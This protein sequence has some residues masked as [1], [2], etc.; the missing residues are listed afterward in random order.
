MIAPLILLALLLAL[1]RWRAYAIFFLPALVY[2]AVLSL[3]FAKP[4][5]RELSDPLLFVPL[6]AL[7]SDMVFG[8]TE[9][10]SRPSRAVK[11]GVA[12]ALVATSLL[13]HVTR[14][15]AP[16]YRLGPLP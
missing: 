10:G 13:V 3:Y 1:K 4:R 11:T 6:A 7:L 14:V 2:L 15:V 9:L 5:F 8:T 12:V 16:W